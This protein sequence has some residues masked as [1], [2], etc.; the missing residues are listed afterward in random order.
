MATRHPEKKGRL[1]VAPVS[2][3]DKISG[4]YV[5]MT[6]KGCYMLF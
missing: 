6:A 4:I 2:P 5:Q 3:L 1:K